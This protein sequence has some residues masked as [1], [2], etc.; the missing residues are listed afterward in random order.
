MHRIKGLLIPWDP[1]GHIIKNPH[2]N[3]TLGIIVTFH[4]APYLTCL[5]AF[6]YIP[7]YPTTPPYS[8]FSKATDRLSFSPPAAGPSHHQLS[9]SLATVAADQFSFTPCLPATSSHFPF[10]WGH[11]SLLVPVNSPSHHRSLLPVIFFMLKWIILQAHVVSMQHFIWQYFEYQIYILRESKW[12][13]WLID[14]ICN[15]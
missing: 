14:M 3:E 1:D 7:Y 11:R 4:F 9:L 6:A 15:D 10:S 12:L 2:H 5:V 13:R 8:P